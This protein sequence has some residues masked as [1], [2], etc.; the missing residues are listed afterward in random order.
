MAL[1]FRAN[2]SSAIHVRNRQSEFGPLRFEPSDC[3]IVSS[4][5]VQKQGAL[6]V[7]NIA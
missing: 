4:K 3:G 7:Q 6:V 2:F 5:N 1:N